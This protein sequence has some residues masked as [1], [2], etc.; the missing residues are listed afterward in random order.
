MIRRFDC[1]KCLISTCVYALI[2][3]LLSGYV[4]VNHNLSALIFDLRCNSLFGGG[5]GGGGGTD[6]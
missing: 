6:I 3:H 2:S 1:L 5:G 4:F